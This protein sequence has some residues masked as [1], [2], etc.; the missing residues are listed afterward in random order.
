MRIILLAVVWAGL[1]FSCDEKPLT[2][3]QIL[4]RSIRYPEG[5]WS[6]LKATMHFDETRPRGPTRKTTVWIDN[7]TGYFKINRNNEEVHGMV[8]DSCFV[9]KGDAGCDRA[10]LLRN[11]YTYLWGLPMK[12]T[13]KGTHLSDA[14]KQEEA[15]GQD[16]YVLKVTYEKDVW[17]YY[18]RQEDFALVAYAFY[19]DEDSGKGEYISTEGTFTYQAINFP[20]NRTWYKLP[21]QEKLGTDVLVEAQDFKRTLNQQ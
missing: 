5:Q 9:E 10:E 17:Y 6:K 13:D 12:L 4:E 3:E 8:R 14:V 15:E 1:L 16:C 7:T 11:Y 20:N 19:K 21:E 2:A 18:I